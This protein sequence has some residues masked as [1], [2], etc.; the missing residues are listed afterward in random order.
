MSPPE[1]APDD[2]DTSPTGRQAGAAT[3]IPGAVPGCLAIVAG[4]G[5]LPRQ[6]VEARRADALPYVVIVFPGLEAEWMAG[7]PVQHHRFERVGALFRGLTAAEAEAVVFAGAMQRPRLR[8]WQA[9]TAAL[10]LLPRALALLARGDDAMLRGFAAI[11]ERRGLRL[12]G[13]QEVLGGHALMAETT[14]GPRRPGAADWADARRAAEIVRALGPLD[15][16]QGAVVARGLCLAVEAAEGTDM[17]LE[18]IAMLPPERRR[19]APRGTGVLLKMP[20]PGQDRRLD[21]PTIGPETV[22]RAAKAGLAGVVVEAG[23]TLVIDAAAVAAV[24]E[25]H[26]LFVTGARPADLAASPGSAGNGAR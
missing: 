7:H 6:I 25:A 4:Q 26:G 18:R 10:M 12:V 8:P 11:F 15:I 24:A 17:M 23:A 1:P 5:A 21:L 3:E 16:G 22:R 13:A 9:D 14:L 20:K 2:T 19:R